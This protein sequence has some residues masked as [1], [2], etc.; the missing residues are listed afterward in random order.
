MQSYKLPDVTKALLNYKFIVF[1]LGITESMK[2]RQRAHQRMFHWGRRRLGRLVIVNYLSFYCVIRFYFYT[3]GAEPLVF[4]SM[5]SRRNIHFW[6]GAWL[7]TSLSVW[8]RWQTRAD[9]WY[10]RWES[11][12]WEITRK[13]EVISKGV[14]TSPQSILNK[15]MF[16]CLCRCYNK[17]TA[18]G[19]TRK[20]V[21]TWHAVWWGF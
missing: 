15:I 12:G 4:V 9:Y 18:W 7:F 10:L 6:A 1:Q 19:Y 3:Y 16:R 14:V 13:K 21:L 17:Q 2:K 5:L 20:T 8:E 11:G